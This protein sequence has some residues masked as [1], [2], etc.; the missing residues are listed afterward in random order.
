MNRNSQNRG[1]NLAM[2]ILVLLVM[3]VSVGVF[4]VKMIDYTELARERDRLEQQKEEYQQKVEELNYRLNS[5]IDYEDIVRLAREKLG[6]AF[7]DETVYYSEQD[8]A[9]K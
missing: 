1:V 8:N 4:I 9:A 2:R 7:P 3:V 5:P 6:L